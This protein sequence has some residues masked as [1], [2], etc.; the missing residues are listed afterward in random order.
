[1]I[2]N[3]GSAN[4]GYALFVR[5]R[6]LVFD[7]NYFHQHAQ[8]VASDPLPAGACLA[9]AR[10]DRAGPGGTVTLLIDGAEVGSVAV[11][12]MATMVSSTGAMS[13]GPTRPSA[14]TCRLQPLSRGSC[15]RS[16]STS[17]RR[18]E[19]LPPARPP[20]SNG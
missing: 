2:V 11:P 5:D 17:P 4:G 15:A 19:I 8:V 14:T 16:R 18:G 6:H 9:G 1:M 12:E 3:R 7:Y 13:D 10:I 20:S